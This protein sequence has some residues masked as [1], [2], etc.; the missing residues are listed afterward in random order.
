MCFCP[1]N[2]LLIGPLE[3]YIV[4]LLRHR[5]LDNSSVFVDCTWT[6]ILLKATFIF[7]V[8]KARK[9]AWLQCFGANTLNNN[10]TEQHLSRFAVCTHTLAHTHTHTDRLSRCVLSDTVW[11]GQP[12]LALHQ[13]SL[14]HKYAPV[15]T[16]T[17]IKQSHR[18]SITFLSM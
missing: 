13:I 1:A 9:T 8:P 5:W 14:K 15:F 7:C 6:K 18:R 16:V 3:W 17:R 11:P 4:I 2:R 12:V 10:I